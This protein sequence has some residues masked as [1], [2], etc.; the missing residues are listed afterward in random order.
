MI[1]NIYNFKKP[2]SIMR[3]TRQLLDR[4][5][6]YMNKK[7]DINRLIELMESFTKN[8]IPLS[9]YSLVGCKDLP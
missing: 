7:L 4:K 5:K 3:I 8:N 2:S 1:T 9:C 6:A